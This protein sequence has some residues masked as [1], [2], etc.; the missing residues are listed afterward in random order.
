V[1]TRHLSTIQVCGVALGI[2]FLVFGIV[3][4]IWPHTG[5]VFHPAN[6]VIGMPVP[7][8]PETVTAKS[9]RVYGVLAILVGSGILG[10]ALYAERK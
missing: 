7:S 8:E 4:I 5:V 3:A 9:S 10:G 2:V 1:N 6:D